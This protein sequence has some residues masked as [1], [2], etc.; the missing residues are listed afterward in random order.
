M[1][2]PKELLDSV[3]H[4]RIFGH[5]LGFSRLG[6]RFKSPFRTDHQPDCKLS[7]YNGK[8]SFFDPP[9]GVKWDILDTFK[10][11][12]PNYT[13]EETVRTILSWNGTA[14]S[15]VNQVTTGDLRQPKS[16]LTPKVVDWDERG[17]AF[18]E[19][20]G[21]SVKDL[22]NP[23]SF[24]Q[25]VCGYEID[26][27][28]DMG[29]FMNTQFCDGFVYWCNDKPKLY[30]PGAPKDRKFRGHLSENDV[31]LLKRGKHREEKGKPDTKT[32]LVGKGNKDL[33]VWSTIVDCDLMNVSAEAVFPTS[34]FLFENVRKTYERVIICFDPDETGANGSLKLKSILD[35]M[36]DIGTFVVK[37]WNW[38]DP[39]TKDLDQYRVDYGR[40][41]TLKFL[42]QNS[43][44]RLFNE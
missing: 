40:D 18:W 37:V 43:F 34:E 8:I 29:T 11:V 1:I 4:L 39:V 17:I 28:N 5:L 26:G 3:D 41:A 7:L 14:P 42:K 38:P 25:Q 15:T 36:S 22:S 27:E 10:F 44:H 20:R 2:S 19:K 24:V 23:D 32:L 9:K 6:V 12:Y 16:V 35:G 30:F 31:W 21:L 33:L 13:W